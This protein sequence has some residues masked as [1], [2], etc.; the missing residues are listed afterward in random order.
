MIDGP[1]VEFACESRSSVIDEHH[2]LRVFPAGSQEARANGHGGLTPF[3][4]GQNPAGISVHRFPPNPVRRNNWQEPT[5]S[6]DAS[7]A[8]LDHVR[9]TNRAQQPSGRA[10]VDSD[11]RIGEGAW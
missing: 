1:V 7:H 6:R 4:D 5:P 9:A 2:M 8:V 10:F 11:N 3:R